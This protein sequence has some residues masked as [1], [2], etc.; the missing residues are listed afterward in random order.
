MKQMGK[1]LNISQYDCHQ[2]SKFA[3][4][5]KGESI[6]NAIEQHWE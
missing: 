1:H 4:Q 6:I 3:A 2:N 5:A